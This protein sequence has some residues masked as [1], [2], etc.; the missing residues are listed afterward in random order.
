MPKDP[1]TDYVSF[2][3]RRYVMTYYYAW[4]VIRL[5]SLRVYQ[6]MW[7]TTENETQKIGTWNPEHPELRRRKSYDIFYERFKFY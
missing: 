7:K 1:S 4:L 2:R 5:K 6:S 3:D